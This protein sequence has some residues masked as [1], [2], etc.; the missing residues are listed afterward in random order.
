[1]VK[2]ISRICE[3]EVSKS[4]DIYHRN[5]RPRLNLLI[6]YNVGQDRCGV[7]KASTVVKIA[8]E[9]NN[10]QYLHFRGIHAYNGK[11]QHIRK[12]SE[13]KTAVELVASKVLHS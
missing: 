1:V 5:K 11:N 13:R 8:R 7:Q 6:E 3:E 2:T 12:Y 4:E 9:I 10:S